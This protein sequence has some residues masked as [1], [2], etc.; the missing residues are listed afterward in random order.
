VVQ[1]GAWKRLPSRPSVDSLQLRR[2]AMLTADVVIWFLALEGAS[3]ARYEGNLG[4]IHQGSLLIAFA[5]AGGLHA[6]AGGILRVYHGRYQIG[7]VDELTAVAM[8]TAIASVGLFGVAVIVPTPR[9][10]PLSV[11]LIAAIV[12]FVLMLGV[13]LAVRRAR[14]L[15]TVPRDAEPTLVFGAG[16]AGHQLIRS[17]LRDPASPYLPVGLLDDNPAKRHSRVSG[18]RMLGTR[19]S[20]A[21]A[22]VRTGATTLVFAIPSAEGDVVRE[23]SRLASDVGLTVKVLPGIAGLLST[24]VGIRDVRDIDLED[25]LGRRQ[26]DTDIGQIAAHLYGRRVLVTGAGGSIGAELCRQINEFSP[27]HLMML[28]RDE[29]A[30]H[31]VQLSLYGTGDLD[32][33]EVALAD[34][35][36]LGAIR[37][38]FRRLKPEVVFHAA[39]LKHVNILESHPEEAWKTNVIGTRNV[40]EAAAM[41]GVTCFVNI[42]TDKAANPVNVLGRSKRVAERLTADFSRHAEG[43]YLSVRFGNV[44]GSRGS[45]LTTFA[46]QIGAGGP[47]TVTDPDVTRYFMTISEA[48]Q[49]LIQAAVIGR[50]GEALVLDMGEPVR[51]SDVAR[52]LIDMHHRS[53]DIVYTGL[54]PGEKMHEE[55]FGDDEADNRPIHHLISHVQV[56]PLDRDS[57]G[58]W[59]IVRV[60]PDQPEDRS[61]TAHAALFG[62]ASDRS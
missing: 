42:S 26:I 43:T 20:I 7:S 25:V 61:K 34:I 5:V 57:V 56:P 48:V 50:D 38:V 36:D 3:I 2:L 41:V 33:P 8:A 37:E 39:A 54:R 19:K 14:E 45:V 35:R 17:M 51:I 6:V 21:T 44:L 31:A 58:D 4:L 60:L 53:L 32:T 9:L 11:P 12:G 40:L 10:V 30:L 15:A 47:V 18:V 62:A 55:L 52:Q 49:L 23:V 29:S 27:G 13:R 1:P 46:A 59:R 24:R 16:D 22:A 28:D